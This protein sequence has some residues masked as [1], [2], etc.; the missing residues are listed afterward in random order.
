MA[1]RHRAQFQLPLQGESIDVR[2]VARELGVRYL[3]QGSLRKDGHR[4]RINAQMVEA[5]SGYQALERTLRSAAQ[6]RLRRCRTRLPSTWSALFSLACGELKSSSVRRKRPES[7]DAYDL[8]LQSQADVDFGM[9]A[10][11]KQGA[12]APRSRASRSTRP[13]RWRTPMRPCAT[14]VSFCA[15]DCMKKI[16]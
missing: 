2:H 1:V 4:V 13:M 3:V 10:Q 5:Q 12:G 8:V 6:R 15:A 9:P 11:V 7:L 14:I 16:G